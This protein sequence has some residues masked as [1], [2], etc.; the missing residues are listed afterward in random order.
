[1]QRHRLRKLLRVRQ[2]RVTL[3]QSQASRSIQEHAKAQ[4]TLD[5]IRRRIVDLELQAHSWI[6]PQAAP[7]GGDSFDAGSMHNVMNCRDQAQMRA[8]EAAASLPRAELAR[9][10][11]HAAAREARKSWSRA[12]RRA[13]A[14][15]QHLQEMQTRFRQR[16]LNREEEQLTEERSIGVRLARKDAE[17]SP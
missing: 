10:R 1:M 14:I 8:R 3:A 11:A 7:S 6:T 16:Q 12:A 15:A 2:L 4:A 17:E 9:Q 5:E 13:D